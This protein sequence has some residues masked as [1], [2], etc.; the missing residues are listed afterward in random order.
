MIDREKL[1][2]EIG[3]HFS[4]ASGKGGQKVNRTASKVEMRWYPMK[5]RCIPTAMAKRFKSKFPNR[6]SKEGAFSLVSQKHREQFANVKDVFERFIE[7]LQQVETPPKRRIPTTPN[8]RSI[9]D[10]LKE[11]KKRSETKKSRGRVRDNNSV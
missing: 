3:F 1:Q 11:K 5:S 7:M 6:H 4:F 10:R 8:Y 2:Q 9:E